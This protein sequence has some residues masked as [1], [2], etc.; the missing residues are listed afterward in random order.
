MFADLLKK[1]VDAPAPAEKSESNR[2][3]ETMDT[4]RSSK[5]ASAALLSEDVEFKGTLCFSSGLELNGRFEGEILAEGPLVI[6]ESAVVKANIKA[7]STVTVRG[8]LQGN[9]DAK[10]KVEIASRAHVY[11]DVTAP[12]FSLSEGAIFVGSSRTSEKS[13]P[14]SEFANLFSRLDKS[15]KNGGG[16]QPNPVPAV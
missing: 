12:K 15:V 3:K 16:T 9:I 7:Q 10:D 4:A 11:G 5:S 2:A 8:K 1:S 14:P 13:T 6:G